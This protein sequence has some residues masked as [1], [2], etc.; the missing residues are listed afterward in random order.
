MQFMLVFAGGVISTTL[1]RSGEAGTRCGCP[2]QRPARCHQDRPHTPMSPVAPEEDISVGG[3]IKGRVLG[4]GG[5][6]L[7][8]VLLTV[9]FTCDPDAD[10]SSDKVVNKAPTKHK[11]DH[12]IEGGPGG[13]DH[14]FLSATSETAQ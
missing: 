3:V 8:Y 7:D 12:G 9:T 13:F 11:F 14:S 4:Q 2:S 10:R 6:W 1:K 5:E